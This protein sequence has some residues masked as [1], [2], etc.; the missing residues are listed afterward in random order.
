[1]VGICCV[2]YITSS[3]RTVQLGYMQGLYERFPVKVNHSS[4]KGHNVHCT[5][6][7][8]GQGRSISTLLY[9]HYN[10]AASGD[11][12]MAGELSGFGVSRSGALA[13]RILG[14]GYIRV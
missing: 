13:W 14:N 11:I 7:C 2:L 12:M 10:R 3:R 6:Y 4:N 9:D 5:V 8:T 1:M